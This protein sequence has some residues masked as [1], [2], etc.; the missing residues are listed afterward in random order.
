MSENNLSF[1]FGN[2]VLPEDLEID[3]AAEYF[4]AEPDL[5]DLNLTEELNDFDINI[6]SQTVILSLSYNFLKLFQAEY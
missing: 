3:K 4:E 2:F 1:E 5:L 6:D